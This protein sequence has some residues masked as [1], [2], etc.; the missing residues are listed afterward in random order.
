MVSRGS[1]VSVLTCDICGRMG[2]HTD[3]SYVEKI[4][5]RGIAPFGGTPSPPRRLGY[6]SASIAIWRDIR[7][8]LLAP[9]DDIPSVILVGPFDSS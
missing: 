9:V 8:L 5:R 4:H 7:Q 6:R 2:C 3:M 1:F